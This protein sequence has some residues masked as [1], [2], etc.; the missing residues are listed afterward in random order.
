MFNWFQ[1]KTMVVTEYDVRY[2]ESV[3]KIIDRHSI[4]QLVFKCLATA[5]TV[6]LLIFA[7]TG[8]LGSLVLPIPFLWCLVPVLLPYVVFCFIDAAYLRLERQFR[9]LYN[10]AAKQEIDDLFSMNIGKYGGDVPNAF[11]MAT[12]WSVFWIYLVN[13][14]VAATV[15]FMVS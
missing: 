8:Y 2:L 10:K 3:Q 11:C 7:G 12:N 15:F 14:I 13:G 4:F 5:F 9:N 6:G 1:E